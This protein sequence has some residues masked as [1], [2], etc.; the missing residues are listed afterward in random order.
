MVTDELA[1][2]YPCKACKA[3]WTNMKL[4]VTLYLEP[5]I[6][7]IVNTVA[8]KAGFGMNSEFNSAEKVTKVNKF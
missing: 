8:K 2:D 3:S 4:V 1:L 6:S 5:A 7:G